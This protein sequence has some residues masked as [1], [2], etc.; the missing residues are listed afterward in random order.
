MFPY[1]LEMGTK[2]NNKEIKNLYSYWS[3]SIT[4]FINSSLAAMDSG[5]VINLAS[6]EYS[7]A[8]NRKKLRRNHY[9]CL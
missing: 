8:V 6:N 1:R 4:G 2:L 7:K 3:N 5:I 9:D